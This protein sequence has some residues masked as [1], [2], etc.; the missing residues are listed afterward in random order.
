LQKGDV[1][2]LDNLAA[3]KSPKAENA[4]R[5]RGAGILLPAA[6]TAN[7][8][9]MASAKLKAL[10]RKKAVRTIDALWTAIRDICALFSP[11]ECRNYFTASGYAPT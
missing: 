3:L 2:I 11:T 1:V 7:P 4:T 9:E 10:L 5:A 6:P 8:I